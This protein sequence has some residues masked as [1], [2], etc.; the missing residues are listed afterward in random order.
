MPEP[1]LKF[2][3]LGSGHVRKG[4]VSS[5]EIVSR[6]NK[7]RRMAMLGFQESEV[8][9][10]RVDEGMNGRRIV[11][12]VFRGSY[13]GRGMGGVV[14]RWRECMSYMLLDINGR[15][16][17]NRLVWLESGVC[18]SVMRIVILKKYVTGSHVCH[19]VMV[20][21][22]PHAFFG[23]QELLQTHRF[24]SYTRMLPLFQSSSA[25][26]NSLPCMYVHGPAR[27]TKLS[28]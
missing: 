11:T 21:I 16:R 26:L 1:F 20:I 28:R 5:G 18:Y 14:R 9:F 27:F 13:S 2:D 6:L 12:V 4:V 3:T 19:G 17:V 7:E 8:S 10:A 24:I 15:L 25:L 22:T 23:S